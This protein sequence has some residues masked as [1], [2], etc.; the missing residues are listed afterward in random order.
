MPSNSPTPRMVLTVICLYWVG[1]F[2]A[3]TPR[4]TGLFE[5]PAQVVRLGHQGTPSVGYSDDGAISSPPAPYHLS[6][7]NPPLYATH[8]LRRSRAGLIRRDRAT[9][10]RDSAGFRVACC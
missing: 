9:G 6:A 5:G 8:P 2:P 10:R 7:I 1:S 3:R 4:K